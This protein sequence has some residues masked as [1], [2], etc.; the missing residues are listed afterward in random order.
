MEPLSLCSMYLQA[1][2]G[3]LISFYV[4][5][6][7][8]WNPYLLPM[9]LQAYDGTLISLFYVL[10][11]VRWNPYLFPEGQTMSGSHALQWF[12]KAGSFMHVYN[13]YIYA[14]GFNVI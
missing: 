4:L 9:Y 10:T 1:Y 11:G 3:T 6:G 13:I 7:V 12:R 2:D 14:Y 5:T 8:R